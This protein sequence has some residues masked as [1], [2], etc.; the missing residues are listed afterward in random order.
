MKERIRVRLEA[1]PVLVLGPESV[2]Y[3]RSRGIDRCILREIS[4]RVFFV[5]ISK[6]REKN[7]FPVFPGFQ[8]N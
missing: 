5:K 6:Y 4:V 3:E 8:E 2:S 1:E 7:M